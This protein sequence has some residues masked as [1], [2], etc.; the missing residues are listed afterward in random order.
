MIVLTDKE[1]EFIEKARD[2]TVVSYGIGCILTGSK[3]RLEIPGVMV[4]NYEE[5]ER[6]AAIWKLV[7]DE[8][9]GDF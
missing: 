8:K 1:K 3:P 9:R 5:R 6:P 4:I 2:T 7:M